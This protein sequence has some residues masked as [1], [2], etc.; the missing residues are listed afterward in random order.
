[1]VAFEI[2]NGSVYIYSSIEKAD[3]L[4]HSLAQP[5]CVVCDASSL[6]TDFLPRIKE[7][8]SVGITNKV[9]TRLSKT[10][11]SFGE[12]PFNAEIDN[13]EPIEN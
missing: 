12:S 11:V 3:E 2:T 10:P 8:E 6:T 5:C 7:E 13:D 9:E 1:M 4:I